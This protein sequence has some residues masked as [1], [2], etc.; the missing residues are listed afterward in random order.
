MSHAYTKSGGYDTTFRERVAEFLRE[1]PEFIE[2]VDERLRAIGTHGFKSL[3]FEALGSAI[4][5]IS[6]A[7]NW[8][9]NPEPEIA[10]R[11]QSIVDKDPFLRFERFRFGYFVKAVRVSVG[12]AVL[13][14]KWWQANVKE[15]R[16][17]IRA[18][19]MVGEIQET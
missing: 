7:D 1:D 3:G 2:L 11:I 12:K 5:G 9:S 17:A 16:R 8:G 6:E 4:L 19:K 10:A 15:V 13:D 14:S 18:V